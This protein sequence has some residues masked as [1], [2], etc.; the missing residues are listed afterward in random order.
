MSDATERRDFLR[1]LAV[2]PIA[3]GALLK[4][5]P[6]TMAHV[7]P[8]GDELWL[9]LC[10]WC[11]F[12]ACCQ[13]AHYGVQFYCDPDKHNQD[14]SHSHFQFIK[15]PYGWGECSF[16]AEAV[17]RKLNQRGFILREFMQAADNKTEYRIE[18][19][20]GE[21]LAFVGLADNAPYAV[22]LLALNI[23]KAGIIA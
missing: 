11:G 19:W 3:G 12:K 23:M 5:K 22:A 7:M 20:R 9:L 10:N 15:N 18:A 2:S 16:R 6:L 1:F 4:R 8:D 21:S 13:N 17:R 14:G